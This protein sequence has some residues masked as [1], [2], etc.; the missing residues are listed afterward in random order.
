MTDF[1]DV[2]AT[3]DALLVISQESGRIVNLTRAGVISSALTIGTA[4]D[5]HEGITMDGAGRIYVVN[6][7]GSATAT[8]QLW[9]YAPSTTPNQAPTAVALT[10]PVTSVP[11]G[12]PRQG[13]RRHASP[14]T[15]SARTR[16]A[17][18]APPSRSTPPACT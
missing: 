15:A 14:T 3:T 1:A 5:G 9:V 4:N 12:A 17:S 10:N 6:E 18:P 2:Y 16:S 7:T 13:R 8:P 11:A